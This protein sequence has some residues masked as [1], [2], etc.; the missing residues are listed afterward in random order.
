MKI[1]MVGG[2]VRDRLLGR[3][4]HDTDWVVVGATPEDM[5]ARGYTPVGRDFPVFL[6]PD[7]HEEY[8]LARTER[9]NGHGYRG[10]V[11]HTAPDVT[12]EE[13]LARRDLTINAIAA[14]ADW[15]SAD[16]LCDPYGGQADLAARVLRHVTDAFREDPVRILRVARFA[17]RFTDFTLAPETL[18]LMREMVDAGEAD[19]LVPERVWQE[20]S[21]GLMEAQPSRMFG[22]LRDCGAL[23]RLLPELDRLWGVPQRAEYHPE[24]DTGVHAMLVLDMAARLDAPLTV[25]FACLCHDFGKGTTPADVLPR[26]IGHEQRSARLLQAVCERWRVPNDCRELADVVAREHGNIHR[27]SELNAAAVLRLL[28][29]CDAIRK[30]ARFAEALLACECDARGRTGFENAA[31]PQRPR[32]QAA[33]DAALAVET[34]PV[35]QAAAQRGLKGKAIGD[36][37]A[38][39]REQ[40]VAAALHALH[41]AH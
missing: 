35:A 2:A 13:D 4:F 23:Q 5:A 1:Y 14:P 10:F 36:A 22:L 31:Y 26:H 9:K 11:V 28:E 20:I 33:L 39:A 40:A 30:P 7:T 3:P 8:A 17:A 15:D 6:H 34:A 37:V 18:Q 27:S 24:V 12:L 32:L 38:Q 29:R 41:P 21:R 25:R 19:H 16:A